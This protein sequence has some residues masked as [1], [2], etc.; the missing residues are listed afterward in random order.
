MVN[1]AVGKYQ[2]VELGLAPFAHAPYAL[3]TSVLVGRVKANQPIIGFENH[4]VGKGLH[5]SN[6]RAEFRQF[7]VNSV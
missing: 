1:V 5:N 4:T 3:V 2:T 6:S 7:M